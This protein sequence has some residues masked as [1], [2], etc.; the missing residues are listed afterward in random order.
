MFSFNEQ[1]G[2]KVVDHKNKLDMY[3]KDLRRY[4]KKYDHNLFNQKGLTQE[5][6]G[7][8]VLSKKNLPR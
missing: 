5:I 8:M 4:Y 2:K 3:S 7:D 1:Q 6:E